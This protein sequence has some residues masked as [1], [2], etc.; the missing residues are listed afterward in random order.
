MFPTRGIHTLVFV[1]E[2]SQVGNIKNT[3]VTVTEAKMFS[4][5]MNLSFSWHVLSEFPS[6]LP[7]YRVLW[8]TDKNKILEP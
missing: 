4:K 5:N 2:N 1:I 8:A 3:D 7:K 6:L